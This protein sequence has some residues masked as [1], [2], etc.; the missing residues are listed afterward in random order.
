MSLPNAGSREAREQVGSMSHDDSTVEHVHLFDVRSKCVLV[1][2]ECECCIVFLYRRVLKAGLKDAISIL[3]RIQDLRSMIQPEDSWESLGSWIRAR[4][5]TQS[6]H[7][8]FT[9]ATF[10]RSLTNLVHVY[11]CV[12]VSLVQACVEVEGRS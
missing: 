5:E 2:V 6:F 3:A 7:S 4:I 9:P 11:V 10:L 1:D 12:C 8:V